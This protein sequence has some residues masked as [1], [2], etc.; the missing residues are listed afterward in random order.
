MESLK[1]K[2]AA[3]F[4]ESIDTRIAVVKSFLEKMRRPSSSSTKTPGIYYQVVPIYDPYGPTRDD[5]KLT[6]IFGSK[7]T[8]KGCESGILVF[9]IIFG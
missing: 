6:A 3:T 2:T 8:E 1:R 5:T 7:E 4:M 9:E